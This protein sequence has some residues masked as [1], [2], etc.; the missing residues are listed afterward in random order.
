[1]N[2]AR[3]FCALLVGIAEGIAK[4]SSARVGIDQGDF[5]HAA[6]LTNPR[7]GVHS[8]GDQTFVHWPDLAEL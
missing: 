3:L 5:F 6:I 8:T 7:E 1:M 4:T 2:L